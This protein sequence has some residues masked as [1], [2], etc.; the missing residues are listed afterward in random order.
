L[1]F[2][3]MH[4]AGNDFVV[5]EGKDSHRNWSELA[6]KMCD[7]HF[8]VG[9]DGLLLIYPSKVAD[10]RMRIFNAD[11]S[12]STVCG[13]GLR[14]L[15]KYYVDSNKIKRDSEIKIKTSD[16]LRTARIRRRR[17]KITDIDVNMGEAKIGL[18]SKQVKMINHN[19]AI[20]VKSVMNRVIKVNNQELQ[21]SL[22]SVGNQHAV[23][24][25][26]N[27]VDKFPLADFGP[28]VENHRL[29]PEETNFEIA[30]II[31]RKSVRARIWERGV[32]ETLA[33]GSGA[34]AITIAGNLLGYIDNKVDVILPGGVLQVKWDIGS[35]IYL[36]GPAE[37][38]FNGEW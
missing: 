6:I 37:T 7:R 11:G 8:G 22:V 15:V 35:D 12:E 32:G 27:S 13:N 21:V 38:V 9:A 33:C 18:N 16:G 34:C 1:K 10:F 14:C 2:T 20:D 4:G 23:C 30:N 26:D 3:K 28:K 5:I 36:R 24:F 29:F 31:N 19:L 25:M 17:N